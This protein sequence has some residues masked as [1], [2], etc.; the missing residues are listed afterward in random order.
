VAKRPNISEQDV[1]PNIEYYYTHLIQNIDRF[2]SRFNIAASSVTQNIADKK[3]D[4]VFVNSKSD[5]LTAQE[6]RCNAFYRMIGF[7]I[8]D[9]EGKNY[10]SP[11]HDPTLNRDVDRQNKNDTIAISLIKK[12]DHILQGREI[13][14]IVS[15]NLFQNKSVDAI[16]RAKASIYI[17]RFDTQF[18]PDIEPLDPDVQT[19]KI[20][21]RDTAM[22][23]RGYDSSIFKKTDA[24]D[25]RSSTHILKPFVVEPRIDRTVTPGV[26]IICAPFL[27][28]KSQT[29]LSKREKL[30]RPYIEHVIRVRLKG[31]NPIKLDDPESHKYIKDLQAQIE[32]DTSIK[33]PALLKAV[34]DPFNMLL[35]SDQITDR[36]IKILQSFIAELVNSINEI[37][38]I[39]NDINWQPIPDVNG[40]EFGST[41]ADVGFD[42]SNKQKENDI[43]KL[44]L[45]KIMTE[46]NS[47]FG[48]PDPDMGD[49][50]F[51]EID[52]VGLDTDKHN[53]E[54]YDKEITKLTRE[55]DEVGNKANAALRKIEIIMGE[56]SGLGLLDIIAIQLVL[57]TISEEAL[58]GLIDEPAQQRMG[59]V[60][61]LKSVTPKLILDSLKE[62]EKQLS[63]IYVLMNYLYQNN[64]DNNGQNE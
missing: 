20:Q 29:Q 3:R 31:T 21:D 51:S 2:R 22:R 41:L 46:T 6:S 59:Q 13:I 11:G 37:G 39:E 50:N 45:E 60:L 10:Y 17:R 44:T 23:E 25:I 1:I 36:Y 57:W 32:T 43:N 33:D 40:P 19:F 5:E 38:R 53:P 58:V 42:K 7:P 64:I 62:F 28:D 47:D 54:F 18:K 34:K 49:Y 48:H 16:T 12:L 61:Y 26:N 14:P 30:K 52:N 63:G 56:F 24:P 15:K 55:R 4:N 35:Q 8:V 9:G 27:T